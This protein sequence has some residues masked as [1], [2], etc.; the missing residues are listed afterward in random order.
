MSPKLAKV[1]CAAALDPEQL[2]TTQALAA[3]DGDD[4]ES[5]D[6]DESDEQEEAPG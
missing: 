2:N 6:D 5:E 3:G 1:G 4:D